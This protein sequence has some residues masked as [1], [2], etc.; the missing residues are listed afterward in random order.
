MRGNDDQLRTD[1]LRMWSPGGLIARGD[2]KVKRIGLLTPYTGGNLGDGAIQD[3]IITNLRQRA[4]DTE[5]Y[6]I[7]LNP[8]DTSARHKIHGFPIDAR[9]MRLHDQAPHGSAVEQSGGGEH[10][11]SRSFVA[12]IKNLAK[13]TPA[14]PLLRRL[15]RLA[16]A[17]TAEVR[18]WLRAYALVRQ[19]DLLVV[20]GGGQ[21]D[22]EWGGPWSH[23]YA[24]FK[25][26]LLSGIARKPYVFLSVGAC[27]LERPLTRF[28]L[29]AALQIAK[30]R[31]CRETRTKAIVDQ[32]GVWGQTGVV[33]DLAFGLEAEEASS[34]RCSAAGPV[35]VAIM[36]MAYCKPTLWPKEDAEIY[37]RYLQS[38]ADMTSELLRRGYHLLFLWS[39][40]MDRFSIGDLTERLDPD[41]WPRLEAQT[42]RPHLATTRDLLAQLSKADFVIATRLHSVLLSYVQ[43]KPTLAISYDA[44]VDMLQ[45]DVGLSGY[46][47]D[48]HH[49]DPDSLLHKFLALER[50]A[51]RI[52]ERL[53]S[54]LSIYRPQLDRQY[55]A[56]MRFLQD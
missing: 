28:F 46:G 33:P 3:T 24:L 4:P 22:D 2:L 54:M 8:R 43:N 5:L 14:F 23:P 21:L 1:R 56:V 17:M 51:P 19:L 25:W 38:L 36:P 30:Y 45:S 27:R 16:S 12:E 53:N 37:S 13:A 40:A 39:A 34:Y 31:S 7:T 41:V 6:G 15:Y 10:N 9:S 26:A 11:P 52:K 20:S 50:D 49:L 44:K 47:I 48:I 29:R 42:E 35:W 18:H 55:D 32:L